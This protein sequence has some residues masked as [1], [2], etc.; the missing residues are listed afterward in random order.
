M[1]TGFKDC[2][3]KHKLPV[4]YLVDGSVAVTGAFICARNIAIALDGKAHVV[5][6]LPTNS[7]IPASDTAIFHSVYRLPIRP[8]RRTLGAV[9]CYLPALIFS[10]AALRM[11]LLHDRVSTLVMNDFYLM[12]GVLCQL[13]GFRGHVFTWVRIDPATFST[14]ITKIW[15]RFSAAASH[16][17]VAVSHHIQ[18]RMPEGFRTQLLYDALAELPPA[19]EH[20]Q[21][22]FVFIGN[23]IPGKGQDHAIEAFAA[24]IREHPN[25]TLDFYGGDMG[26][27]KNRK[28]R[29]Q[30]SEKV[31]DLGLEDRVHLHGFTKAPVEVM[32][33]SLAALNFSTS[34]SFSMTV[35]EA[36]A[37][38][39]PTIA[40]RSGGPAEII[41]D[42]VTGYLVPPGNILAMTEAMRAIADDIK[43]A[44]MMGTAARARVMKHFS[45]E[46]FQTGLTDLLGLGTQAQPDK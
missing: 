35:L 18:G 8:L 15:M 4:I 24:L 2:P 1:H 26:L 46:R 25:L 30:L 3:E 39:L 14:V 40:T 41:E 22:R 19:T 36:S 20:A 32:K 17:M 29:E 6:V 23:Y 37:M 16:R 11:L 31:A 28:Y 44:A 13:M 21:G 27:A 7:T 45:F 33:G 43:G 12:H 10:S 38:G 5:L 34:E 9:L 42:G